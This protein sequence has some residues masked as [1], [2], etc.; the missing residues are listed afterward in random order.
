MF[1]LSFFLT[2]TIKPHSCKRKYFL[3]KFRKSIEPRKRHKFFCGNRAIAQE[4][5]LNLSTG[6]PMGVIGTNLKYVFSI[7]LVL[8]IGLLTLAA[9]SAVAPVPTLIFFGICT[10]LLVFAFTIPTAHTL[11]NAIRFTRRP[12]ARGRPE[13]IVS[14]L[15]LKIML[16]L[17]P[18]A[19][20]RLYLRK[21]EPATAWPGF[22]PLL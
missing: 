10:I 8:L 13:Q 5:K 2:S 7:I 4:D 17:G 11:V 12:H 22:N 18:P 20:S 14:K 21:L 16:I 6:P 9:T 15:K 3:I 1:S 19:G